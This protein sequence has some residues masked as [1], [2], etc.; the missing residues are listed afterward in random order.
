MKILSLLPGL[1]EASVAL[2]SESSMNDFKY[3]DNNIRNKY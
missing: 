3:H 2:S 1:V